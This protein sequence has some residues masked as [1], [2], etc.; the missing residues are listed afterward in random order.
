MKGR[1][2]NGS[3]FLENTGRL[4]YLIEQHRPCNIFRN[5][6]LLINDSKVQRSN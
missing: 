6:Y 2:R 4:Y 5:K 1:A 3:V